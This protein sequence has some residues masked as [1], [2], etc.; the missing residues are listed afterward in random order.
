MTTEAW[1]VSA[2]RVLASAHIATNR[3]ERR[4]GLLGRDAF[5]G[6]F[7]LPHCRCV[8]TIGMRFSLDVA[9]L[10]DDGCIT[11]IIALPRNRLGLPVRH[12]TTVIE[13]Q[14]GAFARWGVRVGDV[15][16]IRTINNDDHGEDSMERDH[17]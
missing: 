7:V 8:H 17:P 15:L 14:Q 10:D 13:A 5:E 3:T 11:K 9:F 4:R 2:G 1:I 6:A 12:S 16:E